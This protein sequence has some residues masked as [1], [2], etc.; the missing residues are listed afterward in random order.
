MRKAADFAA[1]LACSEEPPHLTLTYTE[2]CSDE[3][4]R[5][6]LW[7]GSMRV[8]AAT[9]LGAAYGICRSLAAWRG[10]AVEWLGDHHP[11]Y[12]KRILFLEGDQEVACGSSLYVV[13]P[14]SLVACRSIEELQA[15]VSELC[16]AAISLGF[17]SLAFGSFRGVTERGRKT[18]S[19]QQCRE[20]SQLIEEFGL[21]LVMM[22]EVEEPLNLDYDD[23]F[24]LWPNCSAVLFRSRGVTMTEGKTRLDVLIREASTI[25][26][27][28]RS[29][30]S[31]LYYL[32]YPYCW[33][34]GLWSP[35]LDELPP[36]SSLLFSSAMSLEGFSPHPFW[37]ELRSSPDTSATPLLPIFNSGA[38]GV[39][40]G[41][42]PLLLD[43][44]V[45]LALLRCRRHHFDGVI[46][47]TTALPKPGS[48]AHSNLWVIGQRLWTPTIS[49][50][51]LM[52]MWFS[53]YRPDIDYVK[54]APV[55]R[56][57]TSLA[58]GVAEL[59]A[60][61]T[62]AKS[63]E[64]WRSAL[65]TAFARLK[66]LACLSWDSLQHSDA[67]EIMPTL[68]DYFDPFYVDMRRILFSLMLK[69]HVTLPQSVDNRDLSPGF[70]T[71]L[72]AIEGQ[73]VR[74]GME[75]VMHTT[76]AVDEL[77]LTLQQLYYQNYERYKR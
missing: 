66:H 54:A 53:L 4:Y 41:L 69:H 72:S 65:E 6:D 29:R 17:N 27:A 42:W 15:T 44:L 47:M 63:Y 48:L 36:N 57:A 52:A 50:G 38:V 49:T 24:E 11:L 1:E 74:A 2:G 31:L 18:V 43:H 20:I 67:G 8:T 75:V 64:Q 62:G 55:L 5:S 58:L 25:A 28:L 40:A 71:R 34:Q 60:L 73:S 30:A 26:T 56:E 35:L 76:I 33:R 7:R 68:R 70:W 19:A 45:E 39:G 13:M 37:E 51:E 16:R 77:P 23:F 3:G 21:S 46:V 12:P 14:R 10:K 32:P 61:E 22:T 9:P 59:L